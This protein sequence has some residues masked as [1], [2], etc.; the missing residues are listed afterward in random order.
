M[1]NAGCFGDAAPREI[2]PDPRFTADSVERV[3]ATFMAEKPPAD[4]HRRNI[5]TPWHTSFG[6]GLTK[7]KGVDVA[8]MAQEFVD[9]YGTY[10]PI[11]KRAKVRDVITIAGELRSPASVAGAGLSRVE[12]GKPKKPEELLK[13]ASYPIP[14]PY[15]TY[16]PKGFKTPKVL[17]VNGNKFSIQVPLDD[18]G[19]PGMYGVSVW[20]TFPGS[21]ELRMVS[22]RTVLV[23]KG[24]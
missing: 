13:I 21:K 9:D 11:P 4:G 23:E 3:Q 2:D 14:P 5:L 6:A 17:E 15:V 18:R 16:F 10:D 20:A 1:E 22:L 12:P 8:C 7:A 19:R 24:K